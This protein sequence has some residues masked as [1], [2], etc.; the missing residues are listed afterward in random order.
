MAAEPAQKTSPQGSGAASIFTEL[1]AIGLVVVMMIALTA[2]IALFLTREQNKSLAKPK[3]HQSELP[4]VSVVKADPAPAPATLPEPP[5]APPDHS[6]DELKKLEKHLATARQNI[7]RAELMAWAAEKATAFLEKSL[8]TTQSQQALLQSTTNDL[9]QKKKAAENEAANLAD[10]IARLELQRDSAE[11]ARQLAKN[12]K[13]YSILPYR[14]PSGTWHRPL[15]MECA[16][17][18]AQIMP[19]GPSFRLIDLELAGMSGT[20]IF[21]KIIDLAMRRAAAQ[22]TP[23]GNA[24]TVYVLF[25]VRPSGIK[26]Y[27]EARARLQAQGI[28]FG[29]EL[30]DEKTPI[31][32]PDL[33]DLTQWPGYEGPAQ[34][35]SASP[36]QGRATASQPGNTDHDGLFVWKN[37]LGGQRGP[38]GLNN[39]SAGGSNPGSGLISGNS[40]PPQGQPGGYSA[41]PGRASGLPGIEPG[42]GQPTG[43]SPRVDFG[44]GTL[45]QLRRGQ[46]QLPAGSSSAG[47][48]ANSPDFRPD[49]NPP[50]GQSHDPRAGRNQPGQQSGTNTPDGKSG[51]FSDLVAELNARGEGAVGQL[52]S[53]PG[54]VA[55]MPG[56]LEGGDS[57]DSGVSDQPGNSST[58]KP[59][60]NSPGRGIAA[61]PPTSDPVVMPLDRPATTSRSPFGTPPPTLPRFEPAPTG[62]NKT[63]EQKSASGAP[64]G[65]TEKVKSPGQSAAG[66]SKPPLIASLLGTPSGSEPSAGSGNSGSNSQA[67]KQEQRGLGSSLRRLFGSDNRL[68]EKAWEISLFCDADGLTIRPGEH[69]LR[70]T[71]LQ[72]DPDLLPRTLQAMFEKQLRDQP[73]RYWRPY[74][75]Y[76]LAPG[77]DNLMATAQSQIAEGFIR[78]PSLVEKVPP[79]GAAQ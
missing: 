14:G 75:R 79:G 72:G 40:L 51:T 42:N 23:D 56:D 6:P 30:V 47:G 55:I 35:A 45:S 25:V 67:E 78:W 29:Y 15:P 10:E 8:K 43:R 20:S 9:Q 60:G 37:G 50:W 63:G 64:G 65:S 70:L 26:A 52:Q 77:G 12:F 38:E 39:E 3:N 68:P 71:D 59:F 32:Y 74:L 69:R 62:D 76:R 11:T 31:E 49:L 19:G 22:A 33:G 28:A 27:Y 5:P 46:G 53:R 4:Q 7:A 1:A 24:P 66:G 34:V 57:G 2:S 44:P 61:T 73:E 36:G 18:S 58:K 48:N 41:Q 13:G 54:A 17:D 16:N 21:S